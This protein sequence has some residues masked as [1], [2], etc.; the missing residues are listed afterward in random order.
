MPGVMVNEEGL[1]IEDIELDTLESELMPPDGFEEREHR[2]DYVR[3]L[4]GLLDERTQN[5][6]TEFYFGTPV[7]DKDGVMAKYEAI[8]REYGISKQRVAQILLKAPEKI[9]EEL[10]KR[11]QRKKRNEEWDRKYYP[12]E[13]RDEE[14]KKRYISVNEVVKVDRHKLREIMGIE[15]LDKYFGEK[16]SVWAQV[17][18]K[19]KKAVENA[20]PRKVIYEGMAV[21]DRIEYRSRAFTLDCTVLKILPEQKRIVVMY[22]N[23][24]KDWLPLDM[25]RIRN[26]TAEKVEEELKAHYEELF[27]KK[28]LDADSVRENTDRALYMHEYKRIWVEESIGVKWMKV[29]MSKECSRKTIVQEFNKL[30]R[31]GY[32]EFRSRTGKMITDNTILRWIEILQE[33]EPDNWKKNRHGKWIYLGDDVEALKAEVDDYFIRCEERYGKALKQTKDKQLSTY[34][35]TIRHKKKVEQVKMIQP[36]EVVSLIEADSPVIIQQPVKV[37]GFR[38]I[39]NW[40]FGRS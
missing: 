22:D 13:Y 36:M 11:G 30:Y 23:G 28:G 25:K 6:V 35:K 14:D 38:G 24:V 18:D 39:W 20:R 34:I 10:A 32:P 7:D 5:I 29:Q 31:Y 26:H 9:Q 2:M 4:I 21:G 37:S 15:Y 3:S 17:A 1:D 8:G 40:L 33:T 19:D 12:V 27:R 16:K